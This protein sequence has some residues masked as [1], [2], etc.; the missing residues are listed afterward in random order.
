MG[1]SQNN[2]AARGGGVNMPNG[3]RKRANRPTG[4]CEESEGRGSL[5][6]NTTNAESRSDVQMLD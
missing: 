2:R 6:N 5:G 3:K 1:K 4:T